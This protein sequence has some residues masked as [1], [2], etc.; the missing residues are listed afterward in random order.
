MCQLNKKCC[1]ICLE[2]FKNFPIVFCDDY[3]TC[4]IIISQNILHSQCYQCYKSFGYRSLDLRLKLNVDKLKREKTDCE[5]KLEP[6]RVEL[7]IMKMKKFQN[8]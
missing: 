8:S 6:S 7:D 4:N 5:K 3:K 2:Y 1:V